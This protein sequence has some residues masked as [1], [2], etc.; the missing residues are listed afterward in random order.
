MKKL[1][2]LTALL[3]ASVMGWATQYCNTALTSD[4]TGDKAGDVLNDELYFTASKTGDN[5]T[6]FKLT[7]TKRTITGLFNGQALLQNPGGGTVDGTFSEGWE[8]SNN[9]LQKVVTWTTYPT[10]EIQVY[11][12]ARCEGAPDIT[13]AQ[14]KNIDVSESCGESIASEYCGEV[15]SSG[16]TEAAFTWETTLAG[17]IVISISETLGGA[18]NAT[19][20]RGNGITASKI[21]IGEGRQDL[22]TYFTH[23]GDI[24]GQQSLILTLTDPENRPAEGTKIYVEN[25]IIEYATSKEGNA[26]PSLTF[27]Y[28]YGG[29]CEIV[30]VLTKIV[31]SAAASYAQVGE[32]VAITAQ[33]KDQMNQNMDVDAQFSISPADAG[34]LENG[35]FTFAKVG[36]VTI[37]ATSDD[38]EGSVTIYGVPSDNL[39]LNQPC[40]G[41]YY[42]NNPAE[43]F[44]K[45]N[46]G[47]TNTAWVTYADQPAT[48]EWWYVDLGDKYTLA[49]IDVLWGDPASNSYI[50]QVRDE[51]PTDEQK[52]DD[53]AWETLL[54]V[55]EAGNNSEQFN[56]VTGAGRYVRL[57]SLTKTANFLRLKEVR[58]FG[59]EYVPGGD[60]EA[61]VMVS[62]TLESKTYNTAVIA[63]EATDNIGIA[64]YHVV[65]STNSI[66]KNIV[67]AE[68]KITITGLTPSTE[69]NLV[70]TAI[71]ASQNESAN[72]KSVEFT[73]DNYITAPTAAAEAPTWDASWVK[74]IYS[75]TYSANCGFGEWG[76]S[77]TVTDTEFGKKYVTV[78]GGY[79]GMVD[80]AINALTMEKLHF[81]IWIADDATIRVVPIWGGAEQGITVSLKGQ[82][83]NSVDIALEQYTGITDWSNIYQMKI[84]DAP[85]LTFW[86]GNAYF[87][88]ESELVDDEKPTKVTAAKASESYF[89]VVLT[90][91]AEDNSGAVLYVVKDGETEVG[92][93][94]GASGASVN[95][96]VNN[97]TP[98]TE[99]NF[100]VIAKDGNDNAA[101]PVAVSATTLEA[102]GAAPVPTFA[103]KEKVVPVFTDAQAGGPA[104]EFGPWG[105][106]TVGTFIELAADDHVCYGYNFNFMGWLLTPAV[107]ATDMEF[108][109][110]DLYSATLDKISVTPISPG[111]EGVKVVELTKNEWNCVE[112]DLSA[113]DGKEIDWSNIFQFKFFNADPAGGDLFIDNVYFY[114]DTTTAISNTEAE[115]KAVKVIENGQLIIIKNGVRYTLMGAELR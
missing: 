84:A 107:N 29:V 37:T 77:T 88:R 34:T 70:I 6:T 9:T 82:Q 73:T 56:V 53:E 110:V 80:F 111:H 49:A 15:M 48:K 79:F 10:S 69:Y 7:S 61:P 23:P 83:W 114:K 98:N 89:S 50:L 86:V 16:N 92:S 21:K 74:A 3:C 26:W 38:V 64:K 68:G 85:N 11:L 60:D 93:G 94:A 115:V 28:S 76:S 8:V 78:G 39:A 35:I 13:G 104:I 22:D 91:S 40:E 45:A 113:Y 67:P 71:D 31:V 57:R 72:S 103:G 43:S 51:A 65:D 75:P 17:A 18:D 33:G 46:D 96:T 36:A 112:I 59:T 12:V 55:N 109:H 95:I 97:L 58:V 54:T 41:G 47:N 90:V 19:H 108:L 1:F 25:Q 102:P 63:V 42:D 32:S 66:Y 106:T 44:D 87:Y 52:A 30:P 81:D 105:Q 14:I 100:N 62:A 27:E 24:A 101:E 2:F 4:N 20:F 5:Q 99:Y